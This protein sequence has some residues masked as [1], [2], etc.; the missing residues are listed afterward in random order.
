[1]ALPGISSVIHTRVFRSPFRVGERSPGDTDAGPRGVVGQKAWMAESR[2]G[3]EQR[4]E[5]Q[6][7]PRKENGTGGI[8]RSMHLRSCQPQE[9]ASDGTE[10][11]QDSKSRCCTTSQRPHLANPADA[12]YYTHSNTPR[13]DD[14]C[15]WVEGTKIGSRWSPATFIQLRVRLFPPDPC[16]REKKEGSNGG[17]CWLRHVSTVSYTLGRHELDLPV[18][19]RQTP[20]AHTPLLTAM[21]HG[22]A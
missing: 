21:H 9:D 11:Q 7:I 1:M 17:C 18:Q 8:V 14:S 22:S 6:A 20:L 3:E 13:G 5:H 4:Q 19:K 2:D 16:R 10:W 12:K 15:R